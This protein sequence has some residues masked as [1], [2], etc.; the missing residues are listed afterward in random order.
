MNIFIN[1]YSYA[2]A[3]EILHTV[4]PIYNTDNVKYSGRV[5]EGIRGNSGERSSEEFNVYSGNTKPNT[6]N[7]WY[8]TFRSLFGCFLQFDK[9][10]Q[11]NESCDTMDN[12]LTR[13]VNNIFTASEIAKILS[14]YPEYNTDYIPKTPQIHSLG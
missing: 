1:Q 5:A 10:T 6:T 3:I 8:T 14:S 2:T 9:P 12:S 7:T 4:K 13:Y 11:Y